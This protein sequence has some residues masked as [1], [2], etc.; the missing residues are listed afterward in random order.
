MDLARLQLLDAKM[1]HDK[2]S[3][4]EVRDIALCA[5]ISPM[6]CCQSVL[7]FNTYTLLQ[8]SLV[9]SVVAVLRT[10]L[11]MSRAPLLPTAPPPSP[12][13]ACV[14]RV[15]PELARFRIRATSCIVTVRPSYSLTMT[16][17]RCTLQHV[18][19]LLSFLPSRSES[20]QLTS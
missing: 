8:S 14:T 5:E 1:S 20:S 6:C 15:Q 18:A 11:M 9:Y 17:S 7:D 10:C 12:R 13:C 2:L 4:A 16:T 19:S 3:P